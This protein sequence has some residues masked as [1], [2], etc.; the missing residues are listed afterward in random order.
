MP[1]GK[2]AA[3]AHRPHRPRVHQIQNA[4]GSPA[5]FKIPF[6]VNFDFRAYSDQLESVLAGHIL[7]PVIARE[8]GASSK[9]KIFHGLLDAPLSQIA[10]TSP[11]MT[12][13]LSGNSIT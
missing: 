7:S 5:S 11:A 9:H 3:P 4:F 1:A 2:P 10:G 13:C 12:S 6:A 8:S